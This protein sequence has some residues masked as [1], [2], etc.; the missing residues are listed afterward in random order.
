MSTT[1]DKRVT[2]TKTEQRRTEIDWDRR[3]PV[4]FAVQTLLGEVENRPATELDPLADY[5]DPD[6][7]EAL[8]TGDPEG[9]GPRSVAF[10][11]DDYTVRVSGLGHVTVE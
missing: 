9:Q 2:A 11:Y 3:E 7:L 6:A 1:D 5:I 4:S 8:F 10:E